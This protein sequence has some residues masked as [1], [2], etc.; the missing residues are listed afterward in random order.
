MGYQQIARNL[1]ISVG[2]AYNTF[3]QF[4]ATNDLKP[5]RRAYEHKLNGH[6]ELYIIGLVLQFPSMQLSELVT[7]K[8]GT[9]VSI[10]T[11]CRLLARHGLTRKHIALQRCVSLRASFVANVFTFSKEIYSLMKLEVNWRKCSESMTIQFVVSELL[12][13]NCS[14]TAEYNTD[15]CYFYRRFDG[16]RHSPYYC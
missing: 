5:K 11:M 1:N 4:E 8:S 9:V 13:I 3:K 6:L 14:S 15:C 12:V 16:F 10:S 7:E 2:T